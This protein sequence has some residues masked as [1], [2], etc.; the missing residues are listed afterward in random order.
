MLIREYTPADLD[1]LRRMHA[2]QGFGYAFP[3][4]DDP[5][6]I[7]KLIV[8]DDSGRPVMA[9]LARLTCEMYL[10]IDRNADGPRS[11]GDR[12]AS[13]NAATETST[14]VSSRAERPAPFHW[15]EAPGRA[16]EGSL[17]DVGS[18]ST[19]TRREIPRRSAPRIWRR[20]RERAPALRPTPRPPSRRRTRPSRP[21]PRRRPRLAPPANRAPLRPPPRIPRLA[22]RRLLDPLL[23]PPEAVIRDW[24][25]ANFGLK[26]AGP[27]D[28]RRVG[29]PDQ[30]G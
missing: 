29:Q 26:S 13:A 24:L 27:H 22:P 3:N 6:F 20:G 11:A 8:E 28:L 5:I 12:N 15:R 16:A 21:R 19:L 2:S 23:P 10:L 17:L 14:I 18:E 30:E 9:S 1:A 4:L 7:S 25:L